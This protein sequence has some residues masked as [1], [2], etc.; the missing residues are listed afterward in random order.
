MQ[1]FILVIVALVLPTAGAF[2]E[3]SRL[4]NSGK[5]GPS[6]KL[7]PLKSARPANSC[8]DYGAGFIRIEGTNTCMKVGGA[9]SV[10]AGVSAGSR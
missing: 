6:G 4:P 9:I 1:N 5:A 10:G 2:A 7:L 3:Q 8:A